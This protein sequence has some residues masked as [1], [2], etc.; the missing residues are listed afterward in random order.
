[1]TTAEKITKA[2]GY[3]GAN[4]DGFEALM[5]Q[6]KGH[7]VWRD[8]YNVGCVVRYD[9]PDGSCI[10]DMGSGWDVGLGDTCFCTVGACPYGQHAD[11][12]AAGLGEPE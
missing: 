6:H 12:C 7:A 1:M 11:N 3:D 9:F 8:G 2:L 4:Y 5:E 10:V